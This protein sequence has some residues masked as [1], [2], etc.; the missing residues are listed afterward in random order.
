[1]KMQKIL[2]LLLVC[3]FACFSILLCGFTFFKKKEVKQEQKL[4]QTI[5]NFSD[6]QNDLWC[7]TFQLVWNEFMEKLTDGKPVQFVGGNPQIADELNKQIYSKE[8]LSEKSY[9]I[10]EG[11]ISKSLKRK[12]EKNLKKK[13]DEK[14][15]VLD[16]IN[17]NAKDSYLFYAMLK[18]EFSYKNPFDELDSYSFNS[19]T[20]KVKYFGVNK[21]SSKKIRD[22]VQVLFY[23]SVDEYA[24]RL[25]TNE[26]EDVILFRTDKNDT[27][28]NYYSLINKKSSLSKLTKNDNLK[29]PEINVDKMIS[30]NELTGKKIIGTDYLISQALQ[31]IKFKLDRKGGS[32]KSEAVI[33]I[34]NTSLMPEEEIVRNFFFDKPFVLFLQEQ[35]KDKPYFAMKVDSTKYLVKE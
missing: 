16:F 32:L 25:L 13:F 18:K 7:V 2:S 27:F 26:K 12:I 34:M 20:E 9:Y 24:V 29:I 28:Q 1:M 31:T 14:S 17:W 11:K 5:Q 15:D 8:I 4:E 6:V 10:S 21:A 3:T 33:S 22:N 35:G 23:D 19:S 30:Y